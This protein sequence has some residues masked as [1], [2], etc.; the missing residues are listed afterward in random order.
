MGHDR[1]LTKRPVNLSLNDDLVREARGLTAT[2]SE[3]VEALRADFVDVEKKKRAA[4]DGKIMMPTAISVPRAWK[5]P[6]RLRTTRTMK[7]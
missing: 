6:I 5:P 1:R 3:T 2:L 7:P 4:A